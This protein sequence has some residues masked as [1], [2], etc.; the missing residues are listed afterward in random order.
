M[1]M[2]VEPLPTS[3]PQPNVPPPST[4]TKVRPSDSR[5]ATVSTVYEEL[6]IIEPSLVIFPCIIPATPMV[7]RKAIPQEPLRG[8]LMLIIQNDQVDPTP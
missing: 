1:G 3:D 8:I 5:G 4:S 7:P 6:Y 2:Y